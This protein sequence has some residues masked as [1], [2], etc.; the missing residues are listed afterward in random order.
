[1]QSLKQR[2]EHGGG[3]FQDAHATLHQ[4]QAVPEALLLN[5]QDPTPLQQQARF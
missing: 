5:P 3:A 1:M 2:R 4:P